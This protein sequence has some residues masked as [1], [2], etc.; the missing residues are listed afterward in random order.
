MHSLIAELDLGEA[1]EVESD[2]DESLK[3]YAEGG[4]NSTTPDDV[5][6]V[7]VDKRKTS[8]VSEVS[9]KTF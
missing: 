8:T 6:T 3:C 7:I 4:T 1:W 9:L 2:E 5:V